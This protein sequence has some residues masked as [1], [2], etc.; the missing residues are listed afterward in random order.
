MFLIWLKT[1]W[2]T[3]TAL[4]PDFVVG[5][6]VLD[7]L[8]TLYQFKHTMGLADADGVERMISHAFPTDR[9]NI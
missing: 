6:A 2:M 9:G 5:K 7:Y 4:A 3:I 8:S 1:T